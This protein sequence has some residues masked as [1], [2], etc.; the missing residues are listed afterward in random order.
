[1]GELLS[2]LGAAISTIAAVFAWYANMNLKKYELEQGHLSKVL[3]K[4][5]SVYPE[6]WRVIGDFVHGFDEENHINQ[7]TDLRKE[8]QKHE[9]TNGLFYSSEVHSEVLKII[10]NIGTMLSGNGHGRFTA[11]IIGDALVAL[12]ELLKDDLGSYKGMAVS[13]RGNV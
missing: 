7:L 8:L 11:S 13:K 1:M 4:R 3:D 9:K 10:K 2:Y 6:L 12:R 5:F